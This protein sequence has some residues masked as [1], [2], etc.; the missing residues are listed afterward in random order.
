MVYILLGSFAFL[1]F[2]LFDYYNLRN[3]SLPKNVVSIAGIAVFIYSTSKSI[4]DSPVIQLPIFVQLIST[5]V[6]AM[7]SM[8]LIYSLFIELPFKSTYSS[9]VYN[10]SLVDTGTYALCRHP[11]V[12]WLFFSLIALFF[13]TGSIL[14]VFEAI[15][16]TSIN[17]LY[18]Y[19]QEKIFFCN[20][21][22]NYS[23][24]QK[25]TPMLIP[26]KNSIKKCIKSF[27]INEGSSS[28]L[29]TMIKRGN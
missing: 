5:V 2:F 11:G 28:L 16:W 25:T 18:V 10:N 26:D 12:L 8:L 27:V 29:K 13:M 9:E 3:F 1:L 17:V 20:M 23:D 21:F 14:L 6:F 7:A 22:P 15:V 19:L 4:S 24:Y